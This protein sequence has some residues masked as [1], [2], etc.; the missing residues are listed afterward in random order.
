MF[1]NKSK[2]ITKQQRNPTEVEYL[3]YYLLY[4]SNSA[5]RAFTATFELQ[6]HISIPRGKI[7]QNIEFSSLCQNSYLISKLYSTRQHESRGILGF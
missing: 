6:L 5:L 7:I 1:F 2:T 3:N 4:E